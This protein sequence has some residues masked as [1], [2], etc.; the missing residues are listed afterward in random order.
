VV[1]HENEG[2]H[3]VAQIGQPLG[4][5]DHPVVLV[6]M[7]DPQPATVGREVFAFQPDFYTPKEVAVVLAR[8]LIMVAGNVDNPRALAHFTQQLLHYIVVGL[9]PVPAFLQP[10]AID[11]IPNQIQGVGVVAA[12]EV[13]QALCLTTRCSKVQVGN[14]DRTVAFDIDIVVHGR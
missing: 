5:L 1:Q 10:P 14:P 9:G 7:G 8:K 13:E 3:L 4:I 2:V 12:Q 11:N 6:A